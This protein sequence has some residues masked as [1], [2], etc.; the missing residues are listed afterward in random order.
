[1]FFGGNRHRPGAHV[2][3]ITPATATQW[4]SQQIDDACP[5]N[6][7]GLGSPGPQ[8][9]RQVWSVVPVAAGASQGS[10]KLPPPPP[11]T[12]T[13]SSTPAVVVVEPTCP[14]SALHT[15]LFMTCCRASASVPPAEIATSPYC[16]AGMLAIP[17]R[18]LPRPASLGSAAAAAPDAG[19]ATL[20]VH[21]NR[22]PSSVWA[23]LRDQVVPAASKAA[24][25]T[26]KATV[27]KADAHIGRA[28]T[29]TAA[30]APAGA[31]ALVFQ[32]STGS[33]A[34]SAATRAGS[35]TSPAVHC[36][37][38]C[39]AYLDANS[40]ATSAHALHTLASNTSL[41]RLVAPVRTV[42]RT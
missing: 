34:A 20:L 35:L 28:T 42:A 41:A 40:A 6:G 29:A 13:A 17:I 21:A 19:H 16:S 32:W 25:G 8:S 38:S 24:K 30:P 26:T 23:W 12:P 9:R 37:A 18:N 4:I 15:S 3:I 36:V 5:E 33:S 11:P 2:I 7:D 22:L 10:S 27:D 31:E 14:P 39:P 1:M